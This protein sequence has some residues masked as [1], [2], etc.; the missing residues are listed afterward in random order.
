MGRIPTDQ[1][2]ALMVEEIWDVDALPM[3]LTLLE[4]PGI[5]EK[6]DATEFGSFV[7]TTYETKVTYSD[8]IVIPA[9]Y[10]ARIENVLVQVDCDNDHSAAGMFLNIK[11]GSNTVFTTASAYT[12]DAY[13]TFV[14]R[15]SCS[16]WLLPGSYDLI[17][18]AKVG[19]GSYWGKFKNASYW[20]YIKRMIKVDMA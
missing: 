18:Q 6:I 15:D 2:P 9:G 19:N 3:G 11:V 16:P 4:K 7:N 5:H 14:E 1:R 8:A 17:I 12:G 10:I 20:V 13:D